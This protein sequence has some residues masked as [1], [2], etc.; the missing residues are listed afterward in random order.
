MLVGGQG[1]EFVEGVLFDHGGEYARRGGEDAAGQAR[2]ADFTVD[3][4][5][6]VSQGGGRSA[7]RSRADHRWFGPRAESTATAVHGRSRQ[8]PHPPS[9]LYKGTQPL[10]RNQDSMYC[11]PTR[12]E[13]RSPASVISPEGACSRSATDT[14]TS[15]RLTSIWL[16]PVITE[17]N[18]ASAVD[19]NPGCAIQ[20]AVVSGVDLAKLVSS[21]AGQGEIVRHIVIADGNVRCHAA[22][23][24][25][26]AAMTRLDEQV[27]IGFQ[28][29]AGPW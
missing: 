24:V 2:G 18:A 9:G 15:A 16:G 17:S 10:P 19:A 22:H 7:L 13:P 5:Q 29:G 21:H 27:D 12:M 23:R 26:A 25:S 3:P 6:L 4:I 28:E 14:L 1:E 11:T 8:S 20:G